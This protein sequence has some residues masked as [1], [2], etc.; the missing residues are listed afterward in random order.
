MREGRGLQKS[1]FSFVKISVRHLL[2]KCSGRK[3]AT[4]TKNEM[5]IKRKEISAQKLCAGTVSG[6]THKAGGLLERYVHC[7]FKDTLRLAKLLSEVPAAIW[8]QWNASES[9]VGLQRTRRMIHYFLMDCTNPYQEI[10]YLSPRAA[11]AQQTVS[12]L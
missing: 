8:W 7:N 1:C 10:T 9:Y 2:C 4:P 6:A 11:A 5:T 3:I 12:S